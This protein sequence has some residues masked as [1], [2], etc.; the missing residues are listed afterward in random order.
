MAE[1]KK[2]ILIADDESRIRF[3]LMEMLQ[4][5]YDVICVADGKQLCAILNKC[6]EDLDLVIVDVNMPGWGGE[7]I[8]PTIAINSSIFSPDFLLQGCRLP[9]IY[10]SGDTTL[11]YALHKPIDKEKLLER[12]EEELE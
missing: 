7:S 2:R 11:E 12:I 4:N 3:I 8:D 10:I 1:K 5:D 6:E 9:S